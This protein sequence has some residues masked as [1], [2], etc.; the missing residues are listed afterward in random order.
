[1]QLSKKLYCEFKRSVSAPKCQFNREPQSSCGQLCSYFG[2]SWDKTTPNDNC[3]SL[4]WYPI[5]PFGAGAA[6]VNRA[7]KALIRRSKS[8]PEK[9]LYSSAP[10]GPHM[11]EVVGRGGG[12]NTTF[13]FTKCYWNL[14]EAHLALVARTKVGSNLK[15]VGPTFMKQ[16]FP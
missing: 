14:H 12:V 3:N 5:L 4:Q 1:M 6:P 15:T 10:Q 7:S 11:G 16:F 9:V 8:A 13:E 2:H